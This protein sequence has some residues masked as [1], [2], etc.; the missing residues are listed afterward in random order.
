MPE[1]A[2]ATFIA[3]VLPVLRS[4]DHKRA[5]GMPWLA[6]L[7]HIL[8]QCIPR[9]ACVSTILAAVVLCANF[10][11]IKSFQKRAKRR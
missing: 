6:E 11:G 7:V 5:T 3:L 9:A 1:K 4:G 8:S 10:H 2:F